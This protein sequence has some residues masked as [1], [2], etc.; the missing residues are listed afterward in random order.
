MSGIRWPHR[1]AAMSIVL[2]ALV[3]RL[4]GLGAAPL[5]GDESYYWLWS[6]HLAPSYL[7][8]PAGTALM[9][10]LST[11]LGGEGEAGI[12]WLNAVL[13]AAAVWLAYVVGAQLLSQ[14]AGLIAAACLAVGPPYLVISRFVYTDALQLALLLANLTLLVPFLCQGP[15]AAIPGWRF[16]AVGL[17][18]AALLNT[19]Y[20]AYLYALVV[21]AVLAWQRRDLLADHRTWWAIGIAIAGSVPAVAWN[22]AHG[23]AS[24]RWQWQHLTRSSWR[25]Y[26]PLGNLGHALSYLTPPLLTLS[27]PSVAR[28]WKRP[29]VLLFLPGV[30]MTVPSLLSPADSP[31]NAIAGLSLLLLVSAEELAR[32][33]RGRWRPIATGVVSLL[34]ALNAFLGLGTVLAA[35]GVNLLPHS[36]VAPALRWE[37]SGWRQIGLD[38]EGTLGLKR[39]WPLFAL[40]YSIAGQLRYYA[41]LPV[42]TGWPQYRF[43]E[44]PQICAAE[45]GEDVVQVVGL[46]YLDPMV[47][48][49][50]LQ[51]S[52][53]RVDGPRHVTLREA[54]TEKAFQLWEVE[55]C[56]VTTEMFLERFDFLQLVQA[57]RDG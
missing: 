5:I 3:L 27:L 8:N 46:A 36:S 48:T 11:S 41:R 52:F 14:R 24:Y 40:D 43:W 32:W 30:V 50:R 16:A 31:R 15:S 57:G 28:A 12:R 21:L 13:G 4:W 54:G 1:V 9:V 29:Q 19:K 26:R 39:E 25:A 53:R 42:T 18:M 2:V 55:G 44:G 37:G 45:S 49:E 34:L 47:V 33:L 7:D 23:W 51:E 38:P 35:H 6:K 20:S 10:R 56:T 17:S 22:A